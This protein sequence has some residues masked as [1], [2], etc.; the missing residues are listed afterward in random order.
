MRRVRA[1]IPK[2]ATRASTEPASELPERCLAGVNCGAQKMAFGFI[3]PQYAETRALMIA[4]DELSAVLKSAVESLGWT[5]HGSSENEIKARV[6]MSAF[7]WD[8]D[9]TISILPNSTVRVESKS[10]YKE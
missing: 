10:M 6:P 8:H 3:H 5:D 4:P 9:V 2:P 1:V 7:V